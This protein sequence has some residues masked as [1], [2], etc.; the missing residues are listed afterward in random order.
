[1]NRAQQSRSPA[2]RTSARRGSA[3]MT[4]MIVTMM[5]AFLLLTSGR[6][7]YSVSE[8]QD[9]SAAVQQASLAAEAVGALQEVEL[10]ELAASND[11]AALA[12][13]AT[14]P[15]GTWS[16]TK[17]LGGCMVRWRIEPVLVQ[18]QDGRF[19]INPLHAPSVSL[20]TD[21]TGS[22]DADY[23]N[24]YEFYNFRISTEAYALRD[25]SI[26]N[27]EPWNNAE[28]RRAVAQAQRL[29]QIKLNSLFKYALFYAAEG[30][31]GD[32][33]FHNG[34]DM[35]IN[36]AVHTNG[37]VYFAG[38][39][40]NN[41]G[42]VSI[43]EGG[44]AVNCTL[45]AVDG[46]YRFMKVP[47]WKAFVNNTDA[48]RSHLTILPEGIEAW[49]S[50]NP[51]DVPIGHDVEGPNSTKYQ[52][53]GVAIN[54]TAY[55]SESANDSRSPAGMSESFSVFVRD[56]V[57][58]GATTV[59]TLANIPEL[60]GRPFEPQ[61][62]GSADT[63]LW[64]R[65]PGEGDYTLTVLPNH[66]GDTVGGDYYKDPFGLNSDPDDDYH[67]VLLL[68]DT[69]FAL[70]T[71]G[72]IGDDYLRRS[73]S[74][75]VYYT[76]DPDTITPTQNGETTG[77][78][79]LPPYLDYLRS[80]LSNQAICTAAR[81]V[82]A[83]GMTMYRQV[84]LDGKSIYPGI[85]PPLRDVNDP[86]TDPYRSGYA[87]NLAAARRKTILRAIPDGYGTA[88][89]YDDGDGFSRNEAHG[90]YLDEGLHGGD[91]KNP[92]W[93]LVI[94]ERPAQITDTAAIP[95]LYSP[96]PGWV[97]DF[98]SDGLVDG[99]TADT[100]DTAW[101]VSATGGEFAV[102]DGRFHAQGLGNTVATW[103][104][105]AID[106]SA[107]GDDVEISV[108]LASAGGSLDASGT[109]MDSIKVFYILD[110]GAPV[111]LEER[112]GEIGSETVSGTVDVSVAAS[113]EVQIQVLITAGAGDTTEQYMFDNVAVTG[114]PSTFPSTPI[115]TTVVP[116]D[117]DPDYA[118]KMVD[119][120]R[121]QYVVYMGSEPVYIDHDDDPATPQ[122]AGDY[123]YRDITDLFFRHGIYQADD[124]RIAGVT[125][126]DMVAVDTWA[127]N[128]RE[129]GSLNYHC[130]FTDTD[131]GA[132]ALPHLNDFRYG[133]LD[134]HVDR[135][136]DFIRN[137]DWSR[138]VGDA[139][140]SGQI[141]DRETNAAGELVQRFSGMIFA[142]RTRRVPGTSL[143]SG[144]D[145]YTGGF[146]PI[147]RPQ[148]RRDFV[149]QW[150]NYK[151]DY[152]QTYV[153]PA[154][155]WT[156]AQGMATV[157]TGEGPDVTFTCGVRLTQAE[158][159]EWGGR[160]HN[161]GYWR[162]RG[163]TVITPNQGF[164]WQDYNT[165]EHPD[166]IGTNGLPPC[167]IFCDHLSVMSNSY[168]DVAE[169]SGDWDDS[170]QNAS[171]TT[172]NLSVITNNIPTW[173]DIAAAGDPV[174]NWTV[175]ASGG[176]HN[177]V[178]YLENWGGD[179]YHIKG[180]VVVM[181]RAKYAIGGMVCNNKGAYS[182]GAVFYSPPSRDLQFNSDLLTRPGQ[183]PYTPFGVQVI[184][185]VQ[186]IQTR[187]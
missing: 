176:P 21:G 77:L 35:N 126:A 132:A 169:G 87:T 39:Y 90:F 83:E 67:A 69:T 80:D 135:I 143:L 78:G 157:R 70:D 32:I 10:V 66:D 183:P 101:S 127:R 115:L 167:A 94:R 54:A 170:L 159:T 145:G 137:T 100:G 118:Y 15:D 163:L 7:T 99:N 108:G 8:M 48:M 93:G 40:G 74:R 27:P 22:V 180:S 131:H 160:F 9:H 14:A 24:N 73:V 152:N 148:W 144:R 53:N 158:D 103:T 107:D 3:L 124:S 92:G 60:G 81:R 25:V 149:N 141:K 114:L 64:F 41:N 33:E 151:A 116:D 111:L 68:A 4:T 171:T 120:M 174:S 62:M 76:Q 175:R 177:L 122:V 58:L 13:K 56:G 5:V 165:V 2:P 6:E 16:G 52:V 98:H 20:P 138:V 85:W 164:L 153:M 57:N 97:E 112:Y 71:S 89:T 102:R 12:S 86:L 125:K 82:S 185:T 140:A 139:T 106:V 11:L 173:M 59:R 166:S 178:R 168:S 119:Y 72:R 18:S 45:V 43:P 84:D 161:A 123:A 51:Y 23:L 46:V 96:G 79:G 61:I 50:L 34:P 146:H 19:T 31:D 109:N 184:R 182:S 29:V 42:R 30:K 49:G 95:P 91:I 104:S 147:W 156:D 75:P 133:Y 121:T 154:H 181:G 186:T 65:H 155:G 150:G 129:C 17:W 36:G 130:G 162:P 63:G 113:L 28:Q 38:G 134:L 105:E 136:T 179:T 55:G 110:G 142:H 47:M 44:Y 172:Y 26:E 117:S 187:N 37:A 88:V 128:R 1:M